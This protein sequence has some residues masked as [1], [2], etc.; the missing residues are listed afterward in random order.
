MPQNIWGVQY[1]VTPYNLLRTVESQNL[2]HPFAFFS[3][4]DNKI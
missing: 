4:I 1:V 3:K 2:G